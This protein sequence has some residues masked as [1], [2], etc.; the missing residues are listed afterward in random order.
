MCNA[1]FDVENFFSTHRNYYSFKTKEETDGRGCLG[2][3]KYNNKTYFAL[4]GAKK[5]TIK[6]DS[7]YNEVLKLK[8]TIQGMTH[9]KIASI[10]NNMISYYYQYDMRDKTKRFLVKNKYGTDYFT[11]EDFINK[12]HYISKE[13]LFI[14]KP[15]LFNCVERILISSAELE[16]E[17]FKKSNNAQ[18]IIKWKPCERCVNA[19]KGKI[20]YYYYDSFDELKRDYKNNQLRFKLNRF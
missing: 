10:N 1:L 18:F 12:F 7:M 6:T 14:D 17:D 15:G 4:S 19:V 8:R 5:N 20:V 3:L 16:Y 2:I 9:W 13:E 11:I